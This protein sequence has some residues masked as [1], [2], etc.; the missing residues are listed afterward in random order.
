MKIPSPPDRILH[1][2]RRFVT[3]EWGGT[4]TVILEVSRCQRERGWRPE[5]VTSQA[6]SAVRA[7]SIEGIPVRRHR[8]TYPFLG[9]SAQDRLH[10][11]KK[12]GNLTILVGTDDEILIIS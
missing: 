12:G 8:Y 5:I 10:M 3:H 6:M 4:E 7:D 2:P 11:D 9:L 1:V